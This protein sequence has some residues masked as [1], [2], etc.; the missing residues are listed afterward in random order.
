[1]LRRPAMAAQIECV[2]TD[3]DGGQCFSQARIAAA[4]FGHAVGQHDRRPWRLF[5]C[6]VI[7]EDRGG[8]S[9]AEPSRHRAAY[10]VLLPGVCR[11]CAQATQSRKASA[12]RCAQ[13]AQ[14]LAAVQ[15]LFEAVIELLDQILSA[16]AGWTQ[17][18]QQWNA[19]M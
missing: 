11:H 1:M 15:Q 6:P 10:R 9:G 17:A 2:E 12:N 18:D 3:A 5:G 4:V 19:L 16:V 7:D 13:N 14:V 8:I